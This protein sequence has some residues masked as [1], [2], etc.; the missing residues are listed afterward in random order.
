MTQVIRIADSSVINK[1]H[2]GLVFTIGSNIKKYCKDNNI[3]Y[4]KCFE[5]NKDNKLLDIDISQVQN[6]KISILEQFDE[7]GLCKET[8]IYHNCFDELIADL[9]KQMELIECCN[10]NGYINEVEVLV[11]KN[12]L[13]DGSVVYHIGYTKVIDND[14]GEDITN[15]FYDSYSLIT[16]IPI[17][18]Y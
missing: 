7:Q 2:Y 8:L 16:N 10:G 6:N 17:I 11:T 12:E 1:N 15:I 5:D 14:T 9:K 3:K 4:Y 18:N 13:L